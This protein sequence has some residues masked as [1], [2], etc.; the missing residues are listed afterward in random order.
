M[1]L[2]LLSIS[3]AFPNPVAPEAGLFVRH[4]LQSVTQQ[5]DVKV[6][7]RVPAIDYGNLPQRSSA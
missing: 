5:A 2:R 3:C 4:R 7:A 1:R 6:I